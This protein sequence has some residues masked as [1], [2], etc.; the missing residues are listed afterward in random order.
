MTGTLSINWLCI[1]WKYLK[2]EGK[3]YIV[4]YKESLQRVKILSLNVS[5]YSCILSWEQNT[6]YRTNSKDLV[7]ILIVL[8]QIISKCLVKNINSLM[9][10][11][12]ISRKKCIMKLVVDPGMV[13]NGN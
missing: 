11:D 8:A 7:V 4:F 12:P 9:F 1:Y 3:V 5:L 2:Y 10:S 13:R 6:F